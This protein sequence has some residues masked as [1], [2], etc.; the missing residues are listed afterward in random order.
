VWQK[1]RTG[2]DVF[3]LWVRKRKLEGLYDLP[4][5]KQPAGGS[6]GI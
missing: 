6:A 3:I 5:D 1:E 2:F 4:K